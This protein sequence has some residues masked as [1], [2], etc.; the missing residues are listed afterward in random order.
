MSYAACAEL[1]RKGDPDRFLAAM[2]APMPARGYLFAL[3]AF[4]L[5]IARAPW[6][7]SEPMIAEMRLQWWRD[8]LEECFDGQPARR[9]E[10]AEPL[11]DTIRA[12]GLSRRP[13]D[14]MIDARR[15]DIAKNP[16]TPDEAFAYADDTA[17]NLM[18][19]AVKALGVEGEARHAARFLGQAQGTANFGKSLPRLYA[20]G[21]RA[22]DG[23]DGAALD[24]GVPTNTLVGAIGSLGDLGVVARLKA[25]ERHQ[26][27]PRATTP[28]TAAAWQ[29]PSILSAMTHGKRR[30]D[31]LSRSFEPSEARRRFAILLRGAFGGV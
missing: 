18:T 26:H 21:W 30:A 7:S 31:F 13:L 27:L 4:N 1:V 14:A 22:L 9:H 6:M 16:M 15:R 19:L 3:H 29:T 5:E 24:R 17:G 10:V 2:L 12:T 28:A 20:A 11:V 8:V 25:R 23:W